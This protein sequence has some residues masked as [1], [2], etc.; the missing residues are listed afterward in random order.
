MSLIKH[1]ILSVLGNEN[2][3][4]NADSNCTTFTIKA[5]KLYGLVVTLSAKDNQNTIKKGFVRS[6]L[7][8]EFET[9]SEN[10]NATNEYIY[11]LERN[12]AGVNRLFI[13][14]Y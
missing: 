9:K 13:L 5:I 10:K 2:D 12:F 4:S 7:W 8:N 1:R 6:V 3:N 14:T 11:F